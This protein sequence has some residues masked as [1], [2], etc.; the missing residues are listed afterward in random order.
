M[1]GKTG[2]VVL[3]IGWEYNDEYYRRP[4][5]EGG[6]PMYVLATMKEAATRAEKMNRMRIEA[7]RQSGYPMTDGDDKPI[8][9]FYEVVEVEMG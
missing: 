1:A 5:S 2:Y 8:T 4:E 9:D 7:D 3:E 6:K